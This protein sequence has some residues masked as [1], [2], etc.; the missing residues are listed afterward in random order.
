MIGMNYNVSLRAN[1]QLLI[2]S[3]LLYFLP[4][5]LWFLFFIFINLQIRIKEIDTI[6]RDENNY[7]S[8]SLINFN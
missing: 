8:L 7:T 4:Q 6:I 3:I 1:T 2:L 5:F